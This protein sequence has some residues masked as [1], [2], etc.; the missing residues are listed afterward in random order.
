MGE[1][2]IMLSGIENSRIEKIPRMTPR[3]VLS[4]A[5][6]LM[7]FVIASLTFLLNFAKEQTDF[8]LL[9]TILSIAI[10]FLVVSAMLIVL[11]SFYS[12][13]LLWKA[14]LAIYLG[15]WFFFGLILIYV[16]IASINQKPIELIL[17]EI[18]TQK[19]LVLS[20]IIIS[21]ISILQFYREKI[22]ILN[23]LNENYKKIF[24]MID[25]K[26]P[27]TKERKIIFEEKDETMNFIRVT[28]ELERMLKMLAE[29]YQISIPYNRPVSPRVLMDNLTKKEIISSNIKDS[30]DII[31]KIRNAVIHSGYVEI[32]EIKKAMD[33]AMT[34]YYE[35]DSKL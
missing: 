13:E 6:T 30:F 32:Q 15:G 31:W 10:I 23:N 11:S 28:M 35:L 29:K 2:K 12:S 4:P 14:S 34:I 7:G 17:P 18:D 24:S 25:E 5:A 9:F 21:L 26:E 8:S 16:L 22:T 27:G 19:Y 33:I 1:L 20:S 3:D